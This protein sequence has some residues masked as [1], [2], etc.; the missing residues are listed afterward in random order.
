VGGIMVG[1]WAGIRGNIRVV[2]GAI[3]V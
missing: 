2:G 3:V 1:V